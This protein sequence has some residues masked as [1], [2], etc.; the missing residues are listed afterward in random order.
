MSRPLNR[1]DGDVSPGSRLGDESCFPVRTD[2]QGNVKMEEADDNI[3]KSVRM[4]LGTAKGERVMR[5]EFGCEIHD[6][7]YSSLSPTTLNRIEDSVRT[8]LV[9]WEPRID[10]EDIDAAPAPSEPGKVLIEIEYWIE[11][12][13]SHSNMV[14]PFYVQE[15]SG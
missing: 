14:Y 9:R 3:E 8:A 1:T 6:L 12:T 4:I 15:G 2:N 11:S 7:V 10:V 5:P 13:N